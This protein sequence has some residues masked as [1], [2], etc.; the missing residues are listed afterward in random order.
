MHATRGIAQRHRRYR[1]LRTPVRS[2][3]SPCDN[4][5]LT[6]DLICFRTACVKTPTRVVSPIRAKIRILK[7][8]PFDAKAKANKRDTQHSARSA[9]DGTVARCYFAA[10]EPTTHQVTTL[11][12]LSLLIKNAHTGV[13]I[14]VTCSVFH[15][16]HTQQQ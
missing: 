8:C 4:R 13:V 16:C 10:D 11:I 5:L 3:R 9:P 6:W 7:A 15:V 1:I 12:C 14:P 2:E